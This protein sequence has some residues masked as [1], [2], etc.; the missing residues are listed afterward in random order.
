VIGE[1]VGNYEIVSK[2][3]EGGMGVVYLARHKLIG[4]K[5]AIKL[6]LPRYSSNTEIV[7]R[8]F[9]EA[10]AAAMIDH[11]GLVDVFDYGHHADGS[12]YLAMELLSGDTL[13]SALGR[14]LALEPG[15][16][17][18]VSRQIAS[19]VGAAHA[20]GI[21]HRDLK[22]EN[23]FLV[24]DPDMPAGLRVKVLD[25]GIAKL[26][27]DAE[28]ASKTNSGVLLGTPVYMS[29]EQCRGAGFTDHRTD[30]Y[31]LGCM[32]FE[33]SCGRPPFVTE[34]AGDLLIAHRM[35]PPPRPSTLAQLPAELEVL[36]LWL[37]EKSAGDRPQTMNDVVAAIEA[38]TGGARAPSIAAASVSLLEVGPVTVLG[39][40]APSKDAPHP[41]TLGGAAAQ[42]VGKVPVRRGGWLAAAA[43]VFA[44]AGMVWA[45]GR[46]SDVRPTPAAVPMPA[47]VV[48]ATPAAAP[49]ARIK[50][51]IDSL[52]SG[53]DVFRVS[54]GVRVG[55]TPYSFE[56]E[57][58]SGEAVFTLRLEG[59]TDAA[60]TL[61][62]S[63]SGE[64]KLTLTALPP[65]KKARK[66]SDG[67]IGDKGTIDP[68][69]GGH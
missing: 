11:P 58:S 19:A 18:A 45:L 60:V 39:K 63:R 59:Y 53:A 55:T 57:P 54:D 4:R 56:R 1:T 64:R 50:L 3:G 25:F 9:N 20:Q 17:L 27:G 24:R 42:T 68:F 61:P 47:P 13:A 30:I 35:T 31:A 15:V 44:V 43:V 5:A 66:K 22:P 2:I 23:I 8:F 14:E 48:A 51:S 62:V 38:L 52:P 40:R 67:P 10:R 7:T 21:I 37:L 33:M 16:C 69:P 12:A 41:T 26:S 49:P 36:I 65:P 32:M 29:P 28:P 34:A 46:S 6:L